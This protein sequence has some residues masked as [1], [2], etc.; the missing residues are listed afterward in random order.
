MIPLVN[1][2]ELA[3]NLATLEANEEQVKKIGDILFTVSMLDSSRDAEYL[4]EIVSKEEDELVHKAI[5]FMS[6][7]LFFP[8][9]LSTPTENKEGVWFIFG[10][11]VQAY[12]IGI[13]TDELEARRMADTL[14]YTG[15]HVIFW[16]NG[17]LWDD[18][19][20]VGT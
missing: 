11:D 7:A 6:E 18:L 14:G 15:A 10:W 3:A 5:R 9:N 16:P 17:V 13:H 4:L 1:R 12:P 8:P 19:S 20:K 2:R